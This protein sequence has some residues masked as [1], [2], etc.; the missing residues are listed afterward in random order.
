MIK[1]CS[2]LPSVWGVKPDFIRPDFLS[3]DES[4]MYEVLAHA[5]EFYKKQGQNFDEILLLQPTSPLREVEDYLKLK[6]EY[7][8]DDECDMVVSV[9][10][11]KEN[12]YYTLFEVFENGYIEKS[13]KGDFSRRQDCPEVYAL[14]GALYLI[15]SESML[16]NK[17][18]F[19]DRVRIIEM[20]PSRSVDIDTIEDFEYV[21]YLMQ[22][23]R[24]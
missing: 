6:A 14:N 8:G 17:S 9:T 4:S 3:S 20:P 10:K 18:L 1:R 7:D 24:N 12:P 11:S 22:K 15:K 21:E 5:V 23:T 13:K 16:R 19:S 2:P